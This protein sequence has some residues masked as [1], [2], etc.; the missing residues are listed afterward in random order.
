[1][2]KKHD[3]LFFDKFPT[4]N[5]HWNASWLRIIRPVSPRCKPVSI[6]R[7]TN[8][9][10]LGMEDRGKLIR[11]KFNG[12][13]ETFNATKT[14]QPG[15]I[16]LAD[17]FDNKERCRFWFQSLSSSLNIF[18]FFLSFPN[19]HRV[20]RITKLIIFL[21]KAKLQNCKGKSVTLKKIIENF[22]GEFSVQRV[23]SPLAQ[24]WYRC[25]AIT[26]A[27]GN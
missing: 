14:K 16:L 11:A 15:E 27:A 10:K 8:T 3:R 21:Y 2:W 6:S 18:P 19:L 17:Y 25:G 9:S 20:Y 5:R 26:R 13:R 23:S 12:I 4:E 24:R 1:M 7:N 22:I